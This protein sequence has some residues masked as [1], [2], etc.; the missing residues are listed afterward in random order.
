MYRLLIADDEEEIRNGLADY[1][2]WA[3]VG[4]QV[5]A[6]AENGKQALDLIARGGIDAVLTDIR[7]PLMTG[8]DLARAIFERHFNV[9]VVFL[10]A[11]KDF[12]Y[13]QKAVQYGVRRY[14]LKPTDYSELTAVFSR[15]KKE[16]DA[17][18]L[19]GIPRG[20]EL[21]RPGDTRS[22]SIIE[23]IKEYVRREYANA[24]LSGA[25]RLAHLNPQYVSR[26]FKKATGEHFKEY[27]LKVKMEKATK[28]LS[29][30][31][32]CT[33][34]ISE[35]VGYRNPKNFARSFKRL[36]GVSPRDY[37]QAARRSGLHQ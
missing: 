37:R 29:D 12:A 22:D 7:M 33:Y 35:I 6:R 13:A 11:Y 20:A 1:F 31:G 5:T 17:V 23:S 21:P 28:L 4:F 26:L 34:E 36:F 25:A 16:L 27:L 2:P 18:V 19:S 24:T 15:L 9:P 30:V 14:V 8:I 32:Y 10:S 3:E